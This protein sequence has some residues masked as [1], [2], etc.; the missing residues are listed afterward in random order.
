LQ[1]FYLVRTFTQMIQFSNHITGLLRKF[2][3]VVIPEM[4]G[5]VANYSSAVLDKNKGVVY[6]PSKGIIFNKNLIKNDGLLVSEIAHELNISYNDAL[7]R[8]NDFVAAS[9]QTLQQGGRI[10]LTGLGYLYLDNEKNVQYLAHQTINFLNDSYGLSPVMAIPVAKK[11]EVVKLVEM[12]VEKP[13]EKKAEPVVEKT[14]EKKEAVIISIKEAKEIIKTNKRKYYWVAAVLLPIAF[15]SYWIPFQTN[16]IQTGR[17]SL[18]HF[19]P[20]AKY[21]LPVYAERV[22]PEPIVIDTTEIVPVDTTTYTDTDNLNVEPVKE[23]TYVEPPL[24]TK[25]LH[26]HIIAGCFINYENA[27][28]QIEDLNTGGNKAYLF[29]QASGF[30]RVALGSYATEAEALQQLQ[31]IRANGQPNAW[32]LEE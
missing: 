17:L 8:L 19:N 26:F 29:G 7:A 9:K 5:F 10:E 27:V 2:D 22:A 30:H 25:G 16:A 18:S 14:E 1:G 15:Y 11:V 32:L 3:C 23:S 20:F 12:P 31:E 13:I 21:E 4:G 24:V 28:G 6:P